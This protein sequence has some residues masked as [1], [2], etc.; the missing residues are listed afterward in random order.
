MLSERGTGLQ[1]FSLCWT[2]NM[3]MVNLLSLIRE[4]LIR[5][6]ALMQEGMKMKK[7][8]DPEQKNRGD[9]E[10]ERVQTPTLLTQALNHP[11]SYT[12]SSQHTLLTPDPPHNCHSHQLISTACTSFPMILLGAHLHPPSLTTIT[13]HPSSLIILHHPTAL[14]KDSCH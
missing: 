10:R 8:K 1:T 4:A 14:C 7:M 3:K 11:D 12:H 6:A 5:G 2:C 9:D 13:S